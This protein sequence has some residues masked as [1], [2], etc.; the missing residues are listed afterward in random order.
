LLELPAERLPADTAARWRE[1]QKALPPIPVRE[2]DG[3]RM[4][5]AAAAYDPKRSNC[6]SPELYAVFPFRLYGLG[7]PDLEVARAAFTRRHDR[8][9]NGWPQDGQDA[10]LLGLVDDAA[11]NLLAKARN[12]HR[13]HR[14][15][16]MWGPNFDWC[17][18]QCHGGNLLDTTHRMLMQCDGGQIRV[19]P[20]WPKDWDVTFRLHAPRRT[21]VEVVYRAGRIEKLEVT[22]PA[23]AKDVV[24][25]GD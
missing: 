5:A 7:K 18:D 3:V 23:R 4:L 11:Q 16:A 9:T 12:H 13:A 6:E 24:V 8:F 22:P 15:P 25:G 1:L 17:P 14:F 20:C 2:Q 10:A 19:L 21:V